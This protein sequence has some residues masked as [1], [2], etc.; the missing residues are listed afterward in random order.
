[1]RFSVSRTSRFVADLQERI[2][3]TPRCRREA[4]AANPGGR[5]RPEIVGMHPRTRCTL[6]KRHQLLRAPQ[7]PTVSA[8]TRRIEGLG[9]HVEEMREQTS[10]LGIE[11]ADEL[12]ALGNRD[13]RSLSAARQNGCSWF[14]ARH[15]RAGRNRAAPADTSLCSIS[16]SVPRCKRPIWGSNALDDL[17]IKL[18][19]QDEARRGRGCWGPKL[20][21][22][23]R[24]AASMAPRLLL[25]QRG[26]YQEFP[27]GVPS[28]I[29]AARTPDG[30]DFVRNSKISSFPQ[31]PPPTARYRTYGI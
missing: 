4:S 31:N 17:A 8:S 30:I 27:S 6:I 26:P 23:L 21:V 5:R 18:Q 29:A 15:S 12:P 28:R 9:R 16:F 24:T 1:M 13:A 11:D 2:A 7:S 3:K 14:M 10:D 20:R 19:A 25:M 22:K